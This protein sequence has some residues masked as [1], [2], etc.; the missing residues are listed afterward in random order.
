[1]NLT[2]LGE[3]I[4]IH[5]G[6]NDLVF[7]HHENE[8]AQSESYT[9]KEFARYWV[10]NGMLVFSGE[11]MSKSLGNVVTIDEFLEKYPADVLRYTVLNSGYRNPLTFNE[12]VLEQSSKALE[13]LRSGLKPALPG[14]K[15]LDESAARALVEA[16][17]AARK[18]FE[19]AMDDDFNT[20]G[21]LAALFELVRTIN[22][23]RADG[24]SGEQL[25]KAQSVLR[26][27]TG[28]LGLKL[29]E[30]AAGGG[31]AAPF[32]DLLVEL[33]GEMRRQKLWALADQIRDRL[34]ALGVT[35]EDSKE[36]STWRW[37]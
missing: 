33:R 36:G 37:S 5:G 31:E 7:P 10:H 30:K 22:Q 4:D 26:E 12:E 25:E 35:I 32:V 2:H 11:K 9:G 27:L 1:M 20:S 14:A 6:G 18:G 8:I 34:A 19:E 17:A 29:E 21:A 24:A 13:R 28:V 23:A 15:G 3:Q 16:G